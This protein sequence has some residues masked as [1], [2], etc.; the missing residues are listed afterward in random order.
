MRAECGNSCGGRCTLQLTRID[1]PSRLPGLLSQ[2]PLLIS[3][4]STLDL[5]VVKDFLLILNTDTLA[6]NA[7]LVSRMRP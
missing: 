3:T 6:A 1:A 5:I 7:T 4:I 2:E